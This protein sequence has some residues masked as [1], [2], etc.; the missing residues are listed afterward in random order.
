MRH[1][2]LS[3]TLVAAGALTPGLSA[4][5]ALAQQGAF[6]PVIYINN[7]AVTQYEL[8]Q[9]VRFLKLLNAPGADRDS[10]MKALIEDRLRMQ[11]AA[12]MGI[13]VSDADLQAGLAEFAGRANMDTE[14]FI[15]GLARAGVERQAYRDFVKSGVAW[16]EVIRR[17]I[18]PAI[19]V[20]D[21]EIEQE[22]K[23]Q[24]E[25]PRI[26]RVLLSELI[27]PAPAGQE[28]AVMAQA[29]NLAQTVKSEAAFAAAARKYSATASAP[30]GGRLP[31]TP[32]DNLPPALRPIILGLNPGQI[33]QP[34]TVPG[35]VVLFFLRDEQGQLRPGAKAQE[36]DFITLTLAS[37][38]QASGL[39]AT[40]RS[41]D[42]LYVQARDIPAPQL[43]HETLPQTAIPADV[44]LRLAHLDDNESTIIN[45][46]TSVDLVMLCKRT[47]ALLAQAESAVPST[48]ADPDGVEA[49]TKG[50]DPDALPERDATRNAI[51]NRKINMM[52]DAYLA[53]L[54][55]DAIIRKP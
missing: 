35:A 25:T 11:A 33:S 8:D 32:L 12:D 3:L 50:P 16:R 45:R 46:A 23:K 41:C 19:N 5:P 26:T 39:A 47:P 48:A 44:A 55:A 29:Q 52:A 6:A 36:L 18:V 17:R 1:L 53:E 13:I 34:L 24:I 51:F 22:M 43:R 31:W 40:A 54:R 7:S 4:A 38:E 30:R 37:A 10:A 15:Q 9:R 28:A 49:A 2:L 42:D 14:Q 21:A 20:S 27:I